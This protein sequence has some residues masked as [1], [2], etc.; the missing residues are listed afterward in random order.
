MIH[1]WNTFFYEPLYNALIFLIGVMPGGSVGLAVIVLTIIVKVAL[2]PLS[3]K[4]VTTQSKMRSLEGE[5]SAIK[6]KHKGSKEEQA[7]QTMALYRKHN[8]NPFS[9]CLTVLI[10]LPIILA[11][12][13]VFF[14]GLAPDGSV[15]YSFVHFPEHL[16]T[17]FLGL[18][19]MGKKSL[20]LALIAAATQYF[21][22]DLSLP[23][24]KARNGGE[25]SF[26]DEFSR[27]MNTQ[28]RYMLPVIVG[29]VAYSTSAAVALYWAVSSLFSIGQEL[30]VRRKSKAS[31]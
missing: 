14:K 30:L 15:L 11:L 22:M 27:S 23:K 5:L 4:S 28:M 10:Q 2:Y 3:Q 7:R 18:F 1:F 6:E 9:G 8:V 21:Q 16:N 12:Y 25:I 20:F 17:T 13:F 31:V 26:A 29:F 19:D 24:T